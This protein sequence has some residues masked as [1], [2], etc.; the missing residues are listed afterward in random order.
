MGTLSKA[1]ILAAAVL[2]G[3]A[4]PAASPAAAGPLRA[5]SETSFEWYGYFKFDMAYDSAVS[6][7]GN[8]AMW[9][10][11]HADGNRASTQNITARQTRVGVNIGRE[12]M[13]SKL[14]FDFYGAGAEN[15]NYL[16]MRKA[17]VD[18]PLAS[19]SLR[20]GQDSDLISPLVP[21]TI[22]YT[23]CWGAGNIGYRRPQLRLYQQRDALYWG[24][25]LAR[26]ISPDLDGDGIVD[27]EDAVLPLLQGRVAYEF[28]PGN[29]RLSVGASGHYGRMQLRDG[30]DEDYNTWSANGDAALA[31]SPRLKLLG[32]AY[33][34]SNLATYFGSILNQDTITGLTSRGGWANLQFRASDLLSLSVGGGLDRVDEADVM[35]TD[36]ARSSN[37]VVFG[38]VQHEFSPGVKAGVELSYW[39]TEYPNALA[40]FEREPGNLRLQLAIQGGF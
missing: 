32:E 1:G 23:V 18:V 13:L 34:G 3:L 14:E 17:Y 11:S 16:Q 29:A 4:L 15:K 12:A 27:G 22:N 40:G 8:F 30:P 24:V 9:V 37:S 35:G 39:V 2:V 25:A 10:K 38:N 26:N 36:G 5:D 21:A 7:H 33:V 28:Q 31:I 6:S 19:L 20:A